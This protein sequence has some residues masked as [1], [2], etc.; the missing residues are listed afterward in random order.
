MQNQ[1]EL[2]AMKAKHIGLLSEITGQMTLNRATHAAVIQALE[3][4][5][6]KT[7]VLVAPTAVQNPPSNKKEK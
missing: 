4:L 7:V 3:F 1:Q 5:D 6:K 2:S